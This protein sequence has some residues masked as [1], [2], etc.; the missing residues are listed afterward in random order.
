MSTYNDNIKRFVNRKLLSHGLFWI[1]LLII[2]FYFENWNQINL[3]NFTYFANYIAAFVIFIAVSYFNIYV[4]VPFFLKKKRY[5]IYIISIA[6]TMI[7]GALMIVLLQLFSDFFGLHNENFKQHELTL[8]RYFWHLLTGEFII[9]IITTL[10]LVLDEWNRLQGITI[11]IQEAERQ[12]VQSELQVLKAQIN[13]HFLFN[14]LNNI[15]SH[16]LDQSPKTPEMIMRLSELMSYILYEC[17]DE[18]VLLS[19]EI[20]FLKNYLELEKLR[21][22]DQLHVETEMDINYTEQLIVPLLLIP[23]L[24]NAFKHGGNVMGK[25]P[26]V[27]VKL[28]VDYDAIRFTIVNSVNMNYVNTLNKPGGVGIE[29]VQKRLELLYPSKHSLTI[30]KNENE[31]KVELNLYNNGN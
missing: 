4:L 17:H 9:V 8:F 28:V 19:N 3:L 2:V 5:W 21:F 10:F 18:K 11:N 14:T 25:K 15:Y 7:L 20:A 30:E 13:P 16:S 29:N 12:K 24:E 31:F 22:E 27:R 26:F 23:F 6:T 1:S